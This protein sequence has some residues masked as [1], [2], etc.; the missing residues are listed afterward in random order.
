MSNM[1]PPIESIVN[2]NARLTKISV[3]DLIGRQNISMTTS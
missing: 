1:I 3:S 2:A